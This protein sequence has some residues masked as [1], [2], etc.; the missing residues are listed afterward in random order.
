[1]GGMQHP[2]RAEI[3]R[4]GRMMGPEA[5]AKAERIFAYDLATPHR[6]DV[7]RALLAPWAPVVR[8]RW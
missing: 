3:E 4:I 8:T 1:M 7:P 2:L 5:Q 6:I